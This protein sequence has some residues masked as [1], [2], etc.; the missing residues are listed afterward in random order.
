MYLKEEFM[1]GDEWKKRWVQSV[2]NEDYG[3]FALSHG[4]YFAD[5]Q[6]DKGLQTTENM[7]FYAISRNF[8]RPFNGLNKTLVL[9]FIVKH[10]QTLNCG[11]S[12]VK[13]LTADV[14][15]DS[16]NK[17]SPYGI[18]FG[19]DICGP[20]R[21]LVQLLINSSGTVYHLKKTVPC[22]ADQLSHVYTLTVRTNHNFEI[23][24]DNEVVLSGSIEENF[25]PST[26]IDDSTT[27]Q[28]DDRHNGEHNRRKPTEVSNPSFNAESQLLVNMTA[29][30]IEV[31]QVKAGTIFDNMLVTD[32]P[33][34]AREYAEG[35]WRKRVRL[36][37]IMKSTQT[38][39]EQLILEEMVR[40]RD[41]ASSEM[42]N[43]RQAKSEA[44]AH[45]E[46]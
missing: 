17:E 43:S 14:Q 9:Q 34:Y 20:D 44:A 40:R 35:T 38:A 45:S 29:I 11:G 10:D 8:D 18:M 46:L 6:A 30:G 13:L 36:E 27:Q 4:R 37:Q 25:L 21:K 12:Y 16:F 32:D 2:Y 42:L 24:I 22:K 31:W 1:D 28:T 5:E 3:K 19:P 15:L 7:H 33:E 26:N 23:Q 39:K 41:E